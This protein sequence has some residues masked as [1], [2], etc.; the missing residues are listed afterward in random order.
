MGRFDHLEIGKSQPPRPVKDRADGAV[1]DQFSCL[2]RASGAFDEE[3]Y[4]RA[5]AYYSR[6]LQ[7]EINLE[8]AWLGQI[9][10]L[11][12]LGEI[13]EAVIWS[14]RALER[15]PRSPA[16]LAARGVAEC[17]LG[18]MTE[19][20]GFVD[21]A[22]KEQGATAYAWVARGDVLIPTNETN[23]RFCFGKGVELAPNDW[24]IR[25]WIA[26]AYMAHGCYHQAL[27]QLRFAV[28]MNSEACACWYRI[29]VCQEAL[30]ETEQAKIAYGRAL[31]V[32][33]TFSVAREAVRRLE[34]RDFC[35]RLWDAV[36]RL[37]G[38]RSGG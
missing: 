6:V 14:D 19:A 8:E 11:I 36:R 16:I 35:A 4:E 23:A 20:L 5:L 26:Q 31:A 7:Y 9:R 25:M 37:F 15:F 33:P 30:G 22:L 1:V 34:G 28:G 12:G 21:A 13:Q 32:Q 17:R 3:N 10:C 38:R 27:E 29:G 2:E 18:R 24:R